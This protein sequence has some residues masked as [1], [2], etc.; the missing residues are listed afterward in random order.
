MALPQSFVKWH[1]QTRELNIFN[2]YGLFRRLLSS[3]WIIN[4]ENPMSLRILITIY[5]NLFI[6]L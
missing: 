6:Y 4:I 5:L 1:R 3:L 2:A